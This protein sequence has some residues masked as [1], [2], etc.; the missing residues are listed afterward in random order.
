MFDFFAEY[1][2]IS[3]DVIDF[4][5]G[6]LG[7][8][9]LTDTSLNTRVYT[10]N[11]MYTLDM[12]V[13]TFDLTATG[14]LPNGPGGGTASVAEFGPFDS[15]FVDKLEVSFIGASGGIDNLVVNVPE[16]TAVALVVLGA[17]AAMPVLRRRAAKVA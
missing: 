13:A 11:S 14:I 10:I 7:E 1:E 9:T 3:I 15:A 2:M 12:N 8:I 5:G 6:F 16:P 4:N 17:I